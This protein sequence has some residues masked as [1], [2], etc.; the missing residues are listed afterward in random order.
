MQVDTG[1]NATFVSRPKGP[2]RVGACRS[3][4]TSVPVGHWDL[5]VGLRVVLLAVTSS[6]ARQ[7]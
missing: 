5:G 4:R 1:A 3:V 6:D 2:P 7:S